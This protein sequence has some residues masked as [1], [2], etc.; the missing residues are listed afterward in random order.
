MDAKKK[1]H[2]SS[3]LSIVK[4]Y[5]GVDSQIT[6]FCWNGEQQP[7][8]AAGKEARHVLYI[9]MNSIRGH[10]QMGV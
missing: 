8:P 9:G 10:A 2:T 3:E 4:G 1:S 6:I 7:N 5:L